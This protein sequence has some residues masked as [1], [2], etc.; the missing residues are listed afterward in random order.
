M[1]DGHFS[2]WFIYFED[3][4]NIYSSKYCRAS[5]TGNE[6]VEKYQG[7]ASTLKL[8]LLTGGAADV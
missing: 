2:V 7:R 3:K 4:N 8:A 6:A 1:H 5:R